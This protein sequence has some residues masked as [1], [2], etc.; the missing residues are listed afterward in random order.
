MH[1]D[2][3][4]VA[5]VPDDGFTLRGD[6]KGRS[7]VAHT[8][9][10]RREH[11]EQN[12]ALAAMSDEC[13]S[14]FTHYCVD[15]E[16]P[17]DGV[18]WRW[19]GYASD[20]PDALTDDVAL[21]FQHVSSEHVRYAT[22]VLRLDSGGPVATIHGDDV[23]V[24]DDDS[25][26]D[27]HV[28]AS[29]AKT[30]I[31]SAITILMQHPEVGNQVGDKHHQIQL[32]LA[33]L[34]S[35]TA[36]WQ[37]I[38]THT[39]GPGVTDPWYI[40]TVVKDAYGNV[41][42]PYD[43]M[44]DKNGCPVDWPKDAQG[45]PVIAHHQLTDSLAAITK[46]PLQAAVSALK[47]DSNFK[48]ANWNTL[49]GVTARERTNNPGTVTAPAPPPVPVT[50]GASAA[51]ELVPASTAGADWSLKST[52]SHYGLYLDDASF[53]YDAGTGNISF[54]VTN[55]PN[56]GLGVAWEA[57][58]PDNT[59][60]GPPTYLQMLSPGI[61]VFGIP[62]NAIVGGATNLQFTVPP[63]ASQV[64][65]YLGGLGHGEQDMELDWRGIVY[66]SVVCYGVPSAMIALSVGVQSNAEYIAEFGGPAF[67][68]VILKICQRRCPPSCRFKGEFTIG[69]FL[70]DV[71]ELVPGL[72]FSKFFLEKQTAKLAAELGAEVTTEEL[73]EEVPFVGWV[74]KVVSIAAA[75]ADMVATSIEVGLSPWTYVLEAKRSMALQVEV[76]PDPTH[77]TETQPAIW[78]KEADH[79]IVTVQYKGGTTLRKAGSMPG[80]D[81]TPIS[82][83][84]SIATNDALPS[85][86]GQ[87]FQI[88]ASVYSAT[89]W[90]AGQW[91]SGWIE[92][93]ST[94]GDQRNETGAIIERLVPL[95][96]ATQ[97][98][99][100]EKLTFDGQSAHYVWQNIVFSVSDSLESSLDAGGTVDAAITAAFWGKGVRLSAVDDAEGRRR[101]L[102]HRRSR[103]RRA[104]RPH[105]RG[106]QRRRGRV[107]DRGAQRHASHT[108]GDR[109]R[110]ARSERHRAH[111]HQRER[112][113]LQGRL[114]LP[115]R[116]PEPAPRL[117]QADVADHEPDVPIQ[118]HLVARQPRRRHDVTR[119]RILEPA[120]HRLRPVRPRGAVPTRSCDEVHPAPRPVDQPAAVPADIAGLFTAARYP[121]PA[122]AT[123][124]VVTASA[125]AGGSPRPRASR[126]TTCGGRST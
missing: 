9:E 117:R 65:V 33:A 44:I 94:D 69:G 96:A 105:P 26:A 112:S 10:S 93:V 114:L 51:G 16:V 15:V 27:M 106:D 56:R 52:T 116:R 35:I 86:P 80:G 41:V 73:L 39:P 108:I 95:T 62:V 81:S 124:V 64:D 79:W 40:Q 99:Q 75:V 32:R 57:F 22:D 111:R 84:F 17:T 67:I 6:G 25:H 50:A 91:T 19:I 21:L 34:T 7:L 68:N 49:H 20:D 58:A 126:S 43:K 92:A 42:R 123:A 87:Q 118:E 125:G 83:L 72:I 110:P 77:G 54:N 121:L 82:T 55:W 74:L 115:R 102:D 100:K 60:L 90:V 11:A 78:P 45:Q 88:I 13:R 28:A 37:Y 3:R 97:Y 89:N 18:A 38:S 76:H 63:A 103:R 71:A 101:P 61:T 29:L 70:T 66:T 2:L 47:Q 59:S 8:D 14:K 36:L 1:F 107:R 12:V 48:G 23:P 24:P 5:H 31:M 53:E 4:H 85:A 30:P 122:G 98:Y 119:P 104:V 46:K 120:L 113:R 109:Q